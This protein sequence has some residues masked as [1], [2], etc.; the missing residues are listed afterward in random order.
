MINTSF[1]LI[2]IG[3][4]F[5]FTSIEVGTTGMS[6]GDFSPILYGASVA[7]FILYIAYRLGWLGFN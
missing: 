1:L 3:L 5:Q 6:M 7:E 4:L 2:F